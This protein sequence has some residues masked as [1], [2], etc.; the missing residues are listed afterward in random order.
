MAVKNDDILMEWKARGYCTEDSDM[1]KCR[2]FIDQGR[3]S[4]LAYCKMPLTV[5]ELPNGLFYPWVEISYAIMSGGVF[6]RASGVVKSIKEGDTSI[7]YSTDKSDA[8]TP[9]VDYSQIL[10]RYRRLF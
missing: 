3:Q 4:I 8:F 10:N 1:G 5:P 2:S 6:E 7:T 9:T